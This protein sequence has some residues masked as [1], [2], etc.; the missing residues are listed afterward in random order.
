VSLTPA[1]A[2]NRRFRIM[3]HSS[4]DIIMQQMDLNGNSHPPLLPF[5][6][7]GNNNINMPQFHQPQ[8]LGHP[9]KNLQ[10]FPPTVQQG[11]TS[12]VGNIISMSK[13]RKSLFAKGNFHSQPNTSNGVKENP[14]RN[15]RSPY[16]GQRNTAFHPTNHRN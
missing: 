3:G 12:M 1:L 15:V 14:Y 5:N 7:I 11:P 13:N 8:W 10:N 6:H 2:E 4:A 16:Y 9:M